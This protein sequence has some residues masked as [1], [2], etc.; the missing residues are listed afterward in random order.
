MTCVVDLGV[1]H[2]VVWVVLGSVWVGV[3]WSIKVGAGVVVC[4]WL[5]WRLGERLLA[6]RPLCVCVYV[7]SV[8]RS[9]WVCACMCWWWFGGG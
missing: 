7:L 4:V 2:V 1:S 9:V 6:F 8:C 3:G 5:W